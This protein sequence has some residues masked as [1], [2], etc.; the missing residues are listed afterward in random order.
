MHQVQQS[1]MSYITCCNHMTD[2]ML[3]HC[4]I[5]LTLNAGSQNTNLSVSEASL[6]GSSTVFLSL[7]L[8]ALL[9]SVVLLTGVKGE[10]EMGD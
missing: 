5:M 8:G 4:A 7:F 6:A 9:G 1:T 2:T 3:H 10:M